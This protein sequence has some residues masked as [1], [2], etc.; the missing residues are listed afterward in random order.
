ML[1]VRNKMCG[2]ELLGTIDDNAIPLVFFDPQYR[3]VLDKLGYG[4][5]GERQQGRAALPQ[6][7]NYTITAFM[8]EIDRVLKPRGHLMLWVDKFQLCMGSVHDW[9]AGTNISV[10]DLITWEKQKFGMGYRSRRTCEYLLV[11]QK[12]PLRAKDVWKD[13]GIRD[14]WSEGIEKEKRK[15][16]PHVKPIGLIGRLINC[17]TNQGDVVVDPAA[18]SFTVME[19]A[20]SKN[21]MFLGA[22]IN[23]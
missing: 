3:G 6:M 23:G 14:V 8:L 12:E 2:L 21:R 20:L 18:G 1:N 4:N 11:L 17:V 5:E 9:S 10:V 13:R 15:V 16:H 22:D 7:D 19:A